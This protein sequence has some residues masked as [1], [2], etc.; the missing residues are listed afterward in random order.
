MDHLPIGTTVNLKRCPTHE[1][2]HQFGSVLAVQGLRV[3]RAY[4][5]LLKGEEK[6]WFPAQDVRADPDRKQVIVSRREAGLYC[7]ERQA[8]EDF[9]AWKQDHGRRRADDGVTM[10]LM[11]PYGPEH[12][13]ALHCVLC[14]DDLTVVE[15]V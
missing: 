14:A 5:V 13:V 3:P 15:W 6:V 1:Y 2:K 12:P 11:T 4:L 7:V 10:I 8:F 9:I